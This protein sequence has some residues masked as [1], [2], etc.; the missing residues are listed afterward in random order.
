M[1]VLESSSSV[2]CILCIA[3]ERE[4]GKV[5]RLHYGKWDGLKNGRVG[6]KCMSAVFRAR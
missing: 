4:F 5:V 3:S 2:I 6:F 1:A